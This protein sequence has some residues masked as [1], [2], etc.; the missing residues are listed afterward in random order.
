M[1]KPPLPVILSKPGGQDPKQTAPSYA[2][3]V[4]NPARSDPKQA[5]TGY[6]GIAADPKQRN[7]NTKSIAGGGQYDPKQQFQAQAGGQADPKQRTPDPIKPAPLGDWEMVSPEIAAWAKNQNPGWDSNGN[8]TGAY[9]GFAAVPYT[10]A[11][12]KGAA[13]GSGS[14]KGR[15]NNGIPGPLAGYGMDTPP[16]SSPAIVSGD[17]G[18]Y[19]DSSPSYDYGGY[20]WGDYGGYGHGGRSFGSSGGGRSSQLGL[21]NWRISA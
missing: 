16:M 19:A 15:G 17:G 13:P 10:S 18:G 14:G 4:Y 12:K 3:P 11:E 9:K 1:A 5:T 20:G 6:T 8:P 2:T 7:V 21:I